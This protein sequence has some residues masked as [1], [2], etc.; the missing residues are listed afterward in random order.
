MFVARYLDA[1]TN[2]GGDRPKPAVKTAAQSH[3]SVR[4]F[5]EAWLPTRP[6]PEE[7]A[8]RV[9]GHERFEA[10]RAAIADELGRKFSTATGEERN[11]MREKA[12]IRGTRH[13]DEDVLPLLSPS[14]STAA[15]EGS[16]EEQLQAKQAEL[17]AARQR[18]QEAAD[19]GKGGAQREYV[20]VKDVIDE[21][22]APAQ[23]WREVE[24]R[25]AARA[26]R[27]QADSGLRQSMDSAVATMV[28]TETAAALMKKT[29]DMRTVPQ[30]LREASGVPEKRKVVDN[31][32]SG[33]HRNAENPVFRDGWRY[34]RGDW[35]DARLTENLPSS[36][37]TVD[38]VELLVESL[39]LGRV[40]A[41]SCMSQSAGVAPRL[42]SV[43]NKRIEVLVEEERRILSK[44]LEDVVT[45]S[46]EWMMSTVTVESLNHPRSPPVAGGDVVGLVKVLDRLESLHRQAAEEESTDS[47][48]AV[49]WSFDALTRQLLQQ[50]F[51]YHFA[52]E[53]AGTNRLDRPE[54]ATARF[55]DVWKHSETVYDRWLR[56]AGEENSTGLRKELDINFA[57]VLGKYFWDTRWPLVLDSPQLFAHHLSQ[58]L[59][60]ITDVEAFAGPD[61]AD[62]LIRSL[63][64]SPVLLQSWASG[65][66]SACSTALQQVGS[67]WAPDETRT[68]VNRLA[69]TLMDL[70]ENE[71]ASRTSYLSKNSTAMAFFADAVYCPLTEQFV[72]LEKQKWNDLPTLHGEDEPTARLI[73]KSIE[74]V[75]S[76]ILGGGLEDQMLSSL[77]GEHAN[78]LQDLSQKMAEMITEEC[79]S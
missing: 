25:T 24:D 61:A 54:W 3:Q 11:W 38:S 2:I 57:K 56:E 32:A 37:I 12:R 44:Q 77:L 27:I 17:D 68:S 33:A 79:G 5:L 43:V 73:Q 46:W 75:Y 49:S 39:R 16:L 70:V 71:S 60:A 19:R 58:Y 51:M 21:D 62:E 67:P 42:A 48:T 64:E 66:L 29:E 4:E 55:L 13:Y 52:R 34:R 31:F 76:W 18:L 7:V 22:I 20:A 74:G 41:S 50:R 59:A 26:E 36:F 10:A 23:Y 14:A 47:S 8:W 65:D 15:S 78:E 28:Y 53:D 9:H 35:L 72:A 45:G 30:Q 6:S 40:E 63:T 69:A 1:H